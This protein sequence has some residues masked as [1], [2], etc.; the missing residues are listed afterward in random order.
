VLGVGEVCPAVFE[1][2]R[3]EI[4]QQTAPA[5]GDLYVVPQLRV[6]T[7][8][9]GRQCLQLHDDVV[10]AHE[11]GAVMQRQNIAFVLHGQRDLAHEGQIAPSQS[12]VKPS[13]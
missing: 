7:R 2:F 8:A 4:E 11:I 9:D 13:R 1:L 6:V 3:A 5:A 10:K 12:L